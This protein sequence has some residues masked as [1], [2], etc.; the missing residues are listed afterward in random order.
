M[1]NDLDVAVIGAGPC[2][3]FT[4]LKLAQLGLSVRIFEEHE[5]IGFPS[6]CPGHLSI[7]GLKE[8]GLYPLPTEI[9]EHTFDGANLYSPKGNEFSVNFPSPMT[10]V[11]NR[12]LFDKH[13]AKQ[14]ED[15]G[16]MYHLNSRIDSLIVEKDAVKGVTFRQNGKTEK[17][18][19]SIVVDAEG[20]S[21]RILRQTG[22][23]GLNPRMLVNGVEA[24]V[25][26]VK[27]TDTNKVDVF[28][29]KDYAPGFYAW[30]IPKR[31][32]EANIGLATRSG[33]PAELLQRLML[34]HPVASKKLRVA[35]ITQVRVHP[36]TLG[37]PIQ[38][39]CSN[40][41]LAVGDA[42]SHVKPTTGGGVVF[43]MTC[44]RIAAEIA[45]EAI[46]KNDVSP[47]FLHSYDMRCRK[48]FGFDVKFM[49]RM[50]KTLDA[51]SDAQLD[52]IVKLSSKLGLART[53]RGVRDVDFQGKTLLHTL[54]NPRM[55]TAL[56]FFFLVYFSKN[57]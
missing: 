47:R 6:H 57:L 31:N 7:K 50:R 43:G 4:A 39:A 5:Q 9:V 51:M 27:D 32:D 12:A 49:I 54:P 17:K 53:L 48:M 56:G 29:G 2:G 33:N 55:L 13:V 19:A 11:V 10:C 26:N 23:L 37:G 34:R 14:A 35:R 15:A 45:Y 28:L 42:A 52:R 25:Q 36:L 20:I 1:N 22:L 24:D 44:A 46:E 18:R 8:L 41:F 3:S 30:L 21:S 40:G 38:Q 16:A